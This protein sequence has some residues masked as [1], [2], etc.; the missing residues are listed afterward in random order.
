MKKLD[1]SPEDIP[2]VTAL[3]EWLKQEVVP[4]GPHSAVIG[5][6]IISEIDD[7]VTGIFDASTDHQNELE[8]RKK[9]D[10]EAAEMTEALAWDNEYWKTHERD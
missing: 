2:G 3:A 1:L 4:R 10:A 7:A 5:S 6:F 8:R 9:V